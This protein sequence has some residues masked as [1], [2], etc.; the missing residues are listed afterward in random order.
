MVAGIL[1]GPHLKAQGKAL[2]E[3]A[4]RTGQTTGQ[5]GGGPT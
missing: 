2:A 5:Q 4:S 3:R 1:Q